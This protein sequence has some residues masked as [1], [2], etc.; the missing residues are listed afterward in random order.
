[1]DSRNVHRPH[2]H[3]QHII[4]HCC[5]EFKC[6]KDFNASSDQDDVAG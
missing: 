3:T 2:L 4:R 6:P 5:E 1:M